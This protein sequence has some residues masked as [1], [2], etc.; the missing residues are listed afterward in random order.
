MKHDNYITFPSDNLAMEQEQFYDAAAAQAIEIG[1]EPIGIDSELYK[2]YKKHILTTLAPARA[3]SHVEFYILRG[4]KDVHNFIS[5][6]KEYACNFTIHPEHIESIIRQFKPTDPIHFLAPISLVE[7]QNYKSVEP[8]CLIEIIDGHHRIHA[9]KTLLDAKMLGPYKRSRAVEIW[10]QVIKADNPDG[11]KTQSLFKKFNNTKP[12]PINK[13]IHDVKVLIIEKLSN[14]FNNGT[15]TLI[16]DNTT[17]TF[18]PHIN[19]SKLSEEIDKQIQKQMDISRVDLADINV[20]LII[21]RFKNYNL[22]LL[23]KPIDWF[24]KK[25]E[26]QYYGLS[27]QADSNIYLKAVENRCMLGLIKLEYLISQ[28]IML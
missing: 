28:C 13:N 8:N 12:F 20:D 9:L 27:I 24:N 10:I 26:D 15:F 2:N 5:N 25:T 4:H 14:A 1:N 16:K 22:T 11:P 7:Y 17:K 19:K 6:I 23:Q 3:D 21:E 18:R